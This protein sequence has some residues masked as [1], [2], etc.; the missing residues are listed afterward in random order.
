MNF[1]EVG[2]FMKERREFL[3]LNQL[4]LAEI[5]GVSIKTIYD[6]ELGKGN[7]SFATLLKLAKVLGLEIIVRTKQ[8]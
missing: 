5:A 2:G 4:D 7:P 6:I 8:S 1:Q 3:G